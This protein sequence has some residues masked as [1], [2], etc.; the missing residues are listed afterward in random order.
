LFAGTGALGLEAIS[1]GALGAT[2]IECHF[3]TADLIRQ[4]ALDLGF[5]AICQ[6]EAADVFYWARHTE[7]DVKMPW[8][9]FCSPPYDFYVERCDEMLALIEGLL[10]RLPA[11]SIVIVESDA[12]FDHDQ[13]PR[14]G[15]WNVRRYSPAV[16]GLLRIDG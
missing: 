14:A 12:R 3:P 5:D 16:V 7:L 13:L 15:A 2:L 4:N 9:V 6:I 1:R 10:P 11:A 8:L